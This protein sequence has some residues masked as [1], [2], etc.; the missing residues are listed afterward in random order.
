MT[1]LRTSQ[2][3]AIVR[4]SGHLDS[5]VRILTHFP[6]FQNQLPGF[7]QMFLFGSQRSAA[8]FQ[9]DLKLKMAADFDLFCRTSAWQFTRLVRN[10][11]QVIFK[12]CCLLFRTIYCKVTAMAS[13]WLIHYQ[14][15]PN[16]IDG[17]IVSVLASKINI[18]FL[19]KSHLF[20]RGFEPR[21]GH[22]QD[23]EIGDCC[24]SAKQATLRTKGKDCLV[25]K[26]VLVGDMSIGG[27]VSVG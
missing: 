15:L 9:W 24:F 2:M 16:R 3:L 27:L 10:I 6:I 8:Y 14:L 1:Y 18:Y 25:R 13:N 12:K 19:L 4:C 17:V 20:N 23:Y 26:C 21:S 7:L 5:F 11:H 22:T